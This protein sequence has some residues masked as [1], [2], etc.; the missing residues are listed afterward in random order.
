MIK[1]SK[2]KGKDIHKIDFMIPKPKFNTNIKDYKG[3]VI[4]V[5]TSV[6]E[7]YLQDEFLSNFKNANKI[8]ISMEKI[9]NLKYIKIDSK[10]KE[11]TKYIQS[12]K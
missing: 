2:P 1:R 3:D 5:K 11:F 12:L 4:S 9:E 7:R 10:K 8:M 6:R